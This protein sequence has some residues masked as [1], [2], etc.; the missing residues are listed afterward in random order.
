MLVGLLLG[1]VMAFISV[2][3]KAEQ[4]ISGIGMYLFGLGF[5]ELLYQVYLGTPTSVSGFPPVSIPVLSGIPLI[6]S[7]FFPASLVGVCGFR[8]CADFDVLIAPPSA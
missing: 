6:G 4:G 2:T 7:V 8:S 1:A 3:L 5:S